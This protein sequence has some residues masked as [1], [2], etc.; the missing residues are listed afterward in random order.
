MLL[1]SVAV[2]LASGP[3]GSAA[4]KPAL[5]DIVQRSP[6]VVSGSAFAPS[7]RVTVRVEARV[8]RTKK[9]QAGPGGRFTVR[10]PKLHLNGCESVHVDAFGSRGSR[11]SLAF[12]SVRCDDA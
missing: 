4:G 10:F 9:V 8:S 6:L 2:V 12:E 11:A 7:E 3:A 5:V 1:A